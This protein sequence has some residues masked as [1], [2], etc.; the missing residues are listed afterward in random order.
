MINPNLLIDRRSPLTASLLQEHQN[1]HGHSETEDLH[2]IFLKHHIAFADSITVDHIQDAIDDSRLLHE[3]GN[4]D[5]AIASM[6]AFVEHVENVKVAH[7]KHQASLSEMYKN[8]PDRSLTLSDHV[9]RATNGRH[10]TF[11]SYLETEQT[12]KIGLTCDELMAHYKEKDTKV[13][14]A[15]SQESVTKPSWINKIN[16]NGKIV[17]KHVV[18]WMSHV[19]QWLIIAAEAIFVFIR[20]VLSYVMGH[21]YSGFGVTTGIGEFWGLSG[22]A[23]P[24]IQVCADLSSMIFGGCSSNPC[25]SEFH[26]GKNH[27][28]CEDVFSEKNFGMYKCCNIGEGGEKE[29]SDISSNNDKSG[30]GEAKTAVKSKKV[31]D[32]LGKVVK[33]AS[34]DIVADIHQNIQKVDMV[35]DTGIAAYKIGKEVEG[36]VNKQVNQLKKHVD[37]VKFFMKYPTYENLPLDKKLMVN[38]C[39]AKSGG[40]KDGFAEF[41]D[42]INGRK[43]NSTAGHIFHRILKTWRQMV[44]DAEKDMSPKINFCYDNNFPID[45]ALTEAAQGIPV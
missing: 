12:T 10:A 42:E 34:E 17:G 11:T 6:T 37:T 28:N 24:V 7:A 32:F 29:C 30:K 38:A 39:R 33:K 8:Y 2:S 18:K 19:V 44:K 25:K 36:Q 41:V 27:T 4:S 43:K 3:A 23:G 16:K 22:G 31:T 35:L 40:K 21:I 9:H 45:F 26:K 1:K 20:R 5:P 15:L 13:E 14:V